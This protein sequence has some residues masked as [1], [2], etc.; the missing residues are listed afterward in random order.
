MYANDTHL[1]FASKDPDVLE[2]NLNQELASVNDW[3]VTNKLKC[4]YYEIV[5][6]PNFPPFFK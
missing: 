3:L 6:I 2:Q 5:I 1:A 4:Y